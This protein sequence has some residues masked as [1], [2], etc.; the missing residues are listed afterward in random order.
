MTKP[1]MTR[2]LE[3]LA[4]CNERNVHYF[5]EQHAEDYLTATLT[6]VGSRI[7]VNFSE[8]GIE[9]SV[10]TGSEDVLSDFDALTALI[11]KH[12]Q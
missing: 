3:F 6:L 4:L 7:E 8:S 9:Y 1:A 12:S 11:G 2:M 10:F 5:L